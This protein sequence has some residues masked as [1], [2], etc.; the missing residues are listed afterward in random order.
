MTTRARARLVAVGAVVVALAVW[1]VLLRSGTVEF[2]TI[3][4]PTETAIAWIDA[5]ASGDLMA[6]TG[7]T[8]RVFVFSFVVAS[9]AGVVLGTA[10]GLSRSAYG[11]LHG[12]LEF[13]RFVPPVALI[14]VVLLITGF[15]DRSEVLIAGFASLWPVLLNTASG[16]ESVDP[17]LRDLGRS[18]SLSRRR[19]LFKLVL[20]AA[21][22]TIAVGMRIAMSLALIMVITAEIVAIPRGLGRELVTASAT[23]RPAHVYAYLISI[24]VVGALANL[25]FRVLEQRMFLRGWAPTGETL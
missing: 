9:L 16:V 1:D 24:G 21:L 14:P 22:P 3:P 7:H 18:L 8:L 5:L 20:P 15:T 19:M 13:F 10:I 6:A 23:L 25:A 12:V 2:E 11:Y 4:G 17:Q